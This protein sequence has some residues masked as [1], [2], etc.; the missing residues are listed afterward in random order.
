MIYQ[1]SDLIK[2]LTRVI[3]PDG[4][5]EIASGVFQNCEMLSAISL[6]DTLNRIGEGAF[7]RCL[8][9]R[10]ISIPKSARDVC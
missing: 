5:S 3:V 10:R 4:V 7:S 1:R 9:L 2:T 6:P 8:R